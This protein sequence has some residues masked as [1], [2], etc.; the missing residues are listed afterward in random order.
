[1]LQSIETFHKF[2]F[3]VL[4]YESKIK[5]VINETFL[6]ELIKA[7]QILLNL[8]G[9]NPCYYQNLKIYLATS[10]TFDLY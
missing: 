9:G 3:A 8:I 10:L 5:S 4:A 2:T 7:Y 6:Q 1:M